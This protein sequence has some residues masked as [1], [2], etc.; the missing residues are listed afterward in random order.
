[1]NSHRNKVGF[2]GLNPVNHGAATAHIPALKSFQNAAVL[3][4]LLNSIKI[5]KKN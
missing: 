4:E 2:T 5:P 3:N 1:M